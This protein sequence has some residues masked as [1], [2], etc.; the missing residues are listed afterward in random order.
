M[1]IF[2]LSQYNPQGRG[3][4]SPLGALLFCT[5]QKSK[6]K[7]VPD[8]LPFGFPPFHSCFEEWQKLAS[9]KHLPL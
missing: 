3:V 6:Q 7:K 1:Y 5:P 4:A 2:M 8:S 9:L